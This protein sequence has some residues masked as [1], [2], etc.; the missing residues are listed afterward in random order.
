MVFGGLWYVADAR[1]FLA[2]SL[3]TDGTVVALER[4]RNA[5]GF[6]TDHPVVQFI[7]PQT[8]ETVEIRSR[9]GVR[10]SPFAVSDR[11][12]VAYDP[13]DP[14]RARINSFWTVWFL[15][16]LLIMFGVACATAGYDTLRRARR[17]RGSS[18]GPKS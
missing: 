2:T 14:K 11:V 4:K 17:A 15:P 12:E 9:F 16:I 3:R 1:T 10:P 13:A 18:S 6:D 7:A 5:K 8:N